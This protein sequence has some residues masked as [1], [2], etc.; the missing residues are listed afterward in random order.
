MLY[1]FYGENTLKSHQKLSETVQSL[2]AK[3]GESGHLSFFEMNEENANENELNQLINSTHLFGDKNLTVLKNILKNENAAD[4]CL[5]NLKSLSSSKNIFIFF[6]EVSEGENL[7]KIKNASIK[8]FE[9]KNL[10]KKEL[11]KKTDIFKLTDAFA[12][13]KKREAWIILQ[14]MLL[15]GENEEEIFWKIFW[16][17]KNMASVKMC[18]KENSQTI[19]KKLKIH[20]YVAEKTLRAVKLFTR[21]EITRLSE[22]LIKIYQNNRLNKIEFSA[23]IEH[24]ILNL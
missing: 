13:K 14:K 17:I 19:S 12:E 22:N 23:G 3:K 20:P 11:S 21:E 9:F 18:E 1:L 2:I 7:E 8:S 6:E 15:S 16:Q 24:L 4:F 5:K 10:P